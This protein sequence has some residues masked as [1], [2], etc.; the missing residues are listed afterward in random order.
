MLS[1]VDSTDSPKILSIADST[2]IKMLSTVDGTNP[3]NTIHYRYIALI[4]S[5]KYYLLW[6]SPIHKMLSIVDSAYPQNAIYCR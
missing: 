1:T 5:T 2:Y 4:Q 3:L 6:I